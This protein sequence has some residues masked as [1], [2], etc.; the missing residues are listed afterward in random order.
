MKTKRNVQDATLKNIRLL[1]AR[2]TKVEA[3]VKALSKRCKG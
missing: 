1:K 3:K 2:L